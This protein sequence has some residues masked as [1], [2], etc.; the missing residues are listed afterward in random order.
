MD[1]SVS[2]KSR[3]EMIEGKEAFQ[4][5]DSAMG[6]ILSVSHDELKRREREYQKQA[7]A[8]PNRRGPKK[9]R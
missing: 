8:N 1:Y 3:P 4:R 5:F 6:T 2:M 7:K 9:K